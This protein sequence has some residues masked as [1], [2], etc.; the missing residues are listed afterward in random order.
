ME[1]LFGNRDL[2]M[3]ASHVDGLSAVSLESALLQSPATLV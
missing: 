2:T 3:F 1:R